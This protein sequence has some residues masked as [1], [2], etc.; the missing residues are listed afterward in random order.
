[1]AKGILLCISITFLWATPLSAMMTAASFYLG[2]G[3]DYT[4]VN[5]RTDRGVFASTGILTRA[6]YVNVDF[7]KKLDSDALRGEIEAAKLFPLGDFTRALMI[8]PSLH[9]GASF[10]RFSGVYGGFGLNLYPLVWISYSVYYYPA[11]N[12]YLERNLAEN[13]IRA[14]AVWPL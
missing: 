10:S 6:G 13:T 14:R 11:G 8:V 12:G 1:M 3:V 2:G 9:A 7:G 5:E 4:A